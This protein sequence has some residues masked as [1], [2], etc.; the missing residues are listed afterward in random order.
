MTPNFGGRGSCITGMP[1]H[2]ANGST[3]IVRKFINEGAPEKC[4]NYHP[5]CFGPTVSSR[6][7]LKQEHQCSSFSTLVWEVTSHYRIKKNIQHQFVLVGPHYGYSVVVLHS[8]PP[9]H[10][11]QMRKGSMQHL[12]KLGKLHQ[13]T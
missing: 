8:P 4:S 13:C 5:T 6:T 7:L 3:H 11:M 2:C 1:V 9:S 10:T 12:S